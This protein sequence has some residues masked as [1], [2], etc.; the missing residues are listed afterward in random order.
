ML[1]LPTDVELVGVS[2]ALPNRDFSVVVRSDQFP[3]GETDVTPTVTKT[4][5]TWDWGI[6]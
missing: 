2:T 4:R 3:E 6:Q 5:R 1:D